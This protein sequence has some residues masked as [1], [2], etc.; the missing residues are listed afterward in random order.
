MKTIK[1]ACYEWVQ[2]F[3][4]Y[5]QQMLDEINQFHDYCDLTEITPPSKYDRVYVFDDGEH[6]EITNVS[7][8][9]YTIELNSG[10][11][12]EV[13]ADDF[14]V[15]RDDFFPMWGTMW[16]FGNN[17]DDWWLENNL[18]T[19]A[20][21]GFRIYESENYGYFFGIDGAGYDFYEAHWCKLYKARGLRWHD[22]EE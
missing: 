7:D 11:E 4:A 16:Q 5:Q 9:L 20:D 2:T 18:Q 10:K 22:T 21:C 13:D 14:E 19:M 6:G 12:I 15:Q 8:E 17:V 1:D 3:D